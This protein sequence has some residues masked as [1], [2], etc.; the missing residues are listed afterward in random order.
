MATILRQNHLPLDF[1]PDTGLFL[2]NRR[3]AYVDPC[4]SSDAHS[5]FHCP[6]RLSYYQNIRLRRISFQVSVSD[7]SPVTKSPL[8][9]LN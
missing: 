6:F 9:A 7:L 2:L 8:F 5:L 1:F 3:V 4:L